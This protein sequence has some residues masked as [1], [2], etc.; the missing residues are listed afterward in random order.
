[1][2]NK[3]QTICNLMNDACS[4][5]VAVFSNADA[6]KYADEAVRN[7]F[8]EILGED[9]LTWRGWRNHKNEIFTIIEDVLNTNLPLAWEN[10]TFYNQFVETKNAAL[11]DKNSFI[12]EDNSV[13]VAAS[14]SGNHWDTDRQKLMGRK[15]FSLATEWIFI[16]VYDDF[17][18]FLKGII[19]LPE[20][21]AKM[22][23]AM[24]NEIDS[25]IYSAFNGAGTYLPAS[26]QKTGSYTKAQMSDLIQ[27]VQIATQKNVV[28]AGTKTALANIISGVD[29][30]WVSEKQKEELATTGSLVQL[31]GLGVMAVEIPQTFVR[32]TYD[33][34]VENNK[35]FVLPDNEKFI[36]VFYEGD[37]R[38]RELNEQDTHDQTIDTQVQTKLGVGCVFSNVFGT[39][40]IS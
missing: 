23:K 11:G 32:G 22:Q 14:F 26:F 4:N 13:L 3:L 18:R 7:A 20:L 25:R 15:A 1:M 28:L 29:A 40:T 34:K 12:V 36:K 37:T 8:F 39:Y 19:T 38:A 6:A 27:R 31:T 10:S 2:D 16:R 21:V 30:N 35:I 17:E 24:Q 9:K 33:F 5:R